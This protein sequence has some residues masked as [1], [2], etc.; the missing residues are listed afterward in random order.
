MGAPE[1]KRENRHEHELTG[2]TDA[3]T[4]T[5]RAAAIQSG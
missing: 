3:R 5:S 2:L 4:L 1:N